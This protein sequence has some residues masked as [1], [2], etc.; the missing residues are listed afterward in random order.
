MVCSNS[1]GLVRQRDL[2]DT[3]KWMDVNVWLEG[4][5]VRLASGCGE[6]GKQRCQGYLSECRDNQVCNANAN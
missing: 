4:K 2:E 6:E 5:G 1:D 3:E